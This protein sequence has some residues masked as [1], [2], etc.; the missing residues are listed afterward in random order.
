MSPRP[1]RDMAASVKQRLLDLAKKR[2]EDF[3]FLLGRFAG[4]RFLFRLSQSEHRKD[5]VLKGAMLFHLRSMQAPHRPTRDLDLLGA[6]MPDIARTEAVFQ[7]VCRAQVSDD[8]LTF[9]ADHVKGERIKDDDEYLGIR[10]HLEARMGSARIP[11]QIDVGFGDA[12][13][14][15]PK[16]EQLLALLE[17]P[18]PSVLAYPWETMIA[19]KF[20]AIVELGMDNS[21][22]KDYFDLNYLATTQSFGGPMLAQ[23][24]QATFARRKTPLPQQ[25][26]VGLLPVFGEDTVKQ[27]QWRAFARKLQM[28]EGPLPLNEIIAGL[29]AFLVPP[30]EALLRKHS[31]DKS[32]T[33]GGPWQLLPVQ[34]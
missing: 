5:F 31:F 20:Q 9:L 1:V 29:R 33:P 21:R 22:M 26:P 32:W 10:L 23:A 4:E 16:Q 12:I 24:I 25:T 6:G 28:E 30:V 34:P 11:L 19:E 13:T 2:G 3:S 17:F 18:P 14:P 15:A 7:S 8:G 27:T